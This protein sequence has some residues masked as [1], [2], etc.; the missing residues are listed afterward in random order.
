MVFKADFELTFLNI[1]FA[2]IKITSPDTVEFPNQIKYTFHGYH[3]SVGSVKSAPLVV[4][5][6]SN[7]HNSGKALIGHPYIW[8]ALVVFQSDIVARLVFLDQVI[9]QQQRI[10]LRVDHCTLDSGHFPDHPQRFAIGGI[11][12]VKVAG[13]SFTQVLC[14]TYI[15]NLTFFI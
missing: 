10:E 3:I 13:H 1:L 12:L 4:V 7:R 14:L 2:Q 5:L 15:N 6:V 11:G 8:K 9:F